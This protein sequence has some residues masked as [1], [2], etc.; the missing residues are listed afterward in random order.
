MRCPSGIKFGEILDGQIEVSCRSSRCGKEAGV[1][2]LH[3]FTA[4]GEFIGTKRYREIRKQEGVRDGT[5]SAS[6]AVRPA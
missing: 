1:L 4:E 2:V 5:C 6:P 3:K